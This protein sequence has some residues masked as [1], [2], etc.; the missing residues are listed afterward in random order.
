MKKQKVDTGIYPLPLFTADAVATIELGPLY[1]CQ[2]E[3]ALKYETKFYE[4]TIVSDAETVLEI[5]YLGAVPHPKRL[6]RFP[7][8]NF[9]V[10]FFP[11]PLLFPPPP[12]PSSLQPQSTVTGK[13]KKDNPRVLSISVVAVFAAESHTPYPPNKSFRFHPFFKNKNKTI[14]RVTIANLW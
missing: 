11:L 14:A 13:T 4:R 5:Y 10:P 7:Q 6:Q 1:S 2:R 3:Q 9:D 12:P 8:I